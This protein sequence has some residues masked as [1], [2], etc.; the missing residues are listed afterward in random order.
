MSCDANTLVS[1]ATASAFL[2]QIPGYMLEAV[3]VLLLCA[4]RDGTPLSCDPNTLMQQ[5]NCLMQCIPIGMMP[6]V[7]LSILCTMV[8]Q[9]VGGPTCVN[10]NGGNPTTVPASGCG[11][12]VID[13]SNGRIWWYYN[14]SWQ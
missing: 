7:K 13:T 12:P 14:G 1:S 9:G 6:A 5:A 11:G 8:S 3:E 2:Q 10:L 4:I